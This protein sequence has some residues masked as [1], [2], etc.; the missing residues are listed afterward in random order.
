G[1]GDAVL[2]GAGFGDDPSL[3]HPPGEEDLTHRVVELVRAGVEEV[4]PLE[5]DARPPKQ[6]GETVG[7]IQRRGPPAVPAEVAV[8]F[9]LEHLIR[10]RALV[11]RLELLQRGDQRLRDEAPAVLP[12]APLHRVPF[13]ERTRA[14]NSRI[15]PGSLPPSVSTALLK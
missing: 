10:R 8:E 9:G 1:R 7:L 4:C 12:E 5:I 6:T 3:A 13:H 11:G 15:F 14:M 2:P